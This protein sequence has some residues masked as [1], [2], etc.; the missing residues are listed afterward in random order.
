MQQEKGSISYQRSHKNV[1]LPN[2]AIQN[3][4]TY[5]REGQKSVCKQIITLLRSMAIQRLRELIVTVFLT[6]I[7]AKI[8]NKYRQEKMIPHHAWAYR[9]ST[10]VRQ[11]YLYRVA[12]SGSAVI[13]ADGPYCAVRF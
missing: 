12:H 9:G 6:T 7:G 13:R 4:A 11:N 2:S 10:I 1:S 8:Q 5:G 3:F